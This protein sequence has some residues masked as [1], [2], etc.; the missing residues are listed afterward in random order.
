MALASGDG[1]AYLLSRS[2]FNEVRVDPSNSSVHDHHLRGI[3]VRRRRIGFIDHAVLRW[4]SRSV[5]VLTIGYLF[6]DRGFAHIH[7][8]H[9]SLYLAEL[10]LIVGVVGLMVG[11]DL[12]FRS[13]RF[14]SLVG[15]LILYMSYCA[16]RT[17]PQFG[18]FGVVTTT[19]DASLW[20]Y[21][22]FSVLLIGSFLATTQL[23]DRFIDVFSKVVPILTFWLPIA[24]VLE[25][26]GVKG[27]RF[28]YSNVALLSHKPGN[29]CVVA[30][31]CLLWV[32]LVPSARRSAWYRS[33]LV[34]VNLLTILA[35]MTQTR[36]GGLAALIA[37]SGGIALLGARRIRVLM[38]AVVVSLVILAFS[39]TTNFSYHTKHRTI[40]ASQLLQNISSVGGGQSTNSQLSGT[41]TF[42]VDLWGEILSRQAS[43]SHLI[44]GFGFGPNLAAIGGLAPKPNQSK[45]LDLRSAH[46]SLLDIF[47]RTGIIGSI[48]FVLLWSGWWRRLVMARRHARYIDDDRSRGVMGV[49][50]LGALAIFIN[51]FFDPTLEGPQV[52]VVL[53]M[54]FA[55]GL[56]LARKTLTTPIKS[57]TRESRGVAL[58]RS[59]TSPLTSNDIND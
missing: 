52:D 5:G 33:T 13:I 30:A 47:A 46:N 27:P 8:P 4:F 25:R 34:V 26:S 50:L 2:G 37:V 7:V 38:T 16:L 28:K 6:F 10:V 14:D 45:I 23:P 57:R 41:V 40:S 12:V 9:A 44:D 36:G 19:R 58:L 18:T 1:V 49:C 3:E 22:A 20:Y 42:R 56:F 15:V 24:L 32:W 43:T 53:F 29:I 31:I 17:F 39:V 11:T 54:I 55:L 48:T 35:G 59:D 21:G 51:S